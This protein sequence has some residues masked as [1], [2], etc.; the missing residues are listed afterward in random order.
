MSR[1]ERPPNRR[2]SVALGTLVVLTIAFGFW[3]KLTRPKTAR[4]PLGIAGFELGQAG[5]GE[6]RVRTTFFD[7]PAECTLS[8]GN[9]RKLDEIRCSLEAGS[10]PERRRQLRGKMLATLRQLYGEETRASAA[11]ELEHWEWA[12]DRALLTLEM[13]PVLATTGGIEVTNKQRR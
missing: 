6:Q 9:S 4:V 7:E 1:A 8:F 11:P 3:V 5:E 12:N 10:T 2:L 13:P